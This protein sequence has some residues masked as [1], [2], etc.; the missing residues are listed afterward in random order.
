M[1]K[2][3]LCCD[4]DN[5]LLYS[6]KHKQKNDI[7]VEWLHGKEQGFMTLKAYQ[8]FQMLCQRISIVPVT[9]RS[10]EQYKR[11]RLPKE[12]SIEYAVTT[13]GA[14]LLHNGEMD[15]EWYTKS[16]EQVVPYQTELKR[17]QNILIEQ[18]KYLRCRIID[19]M[20]L[21]AYGKEGIDINECVREYTEKTPLTVMA[22]GRKIYFLPPSINKGETMIR[23]KQRLK[24]EFVAAAGDSK[25]DL[26]MLKE[27]DLAIVPN[28]YLGKFLPKS[29]TVVCDPDKNFSEFLLEIMM[30][31]LS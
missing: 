1:K 23:L 2:I 21:F 14:I 8:L 12:D 28:Q 29:N 10:L 16:F 6:Y 13:N 15:R 19:D 26:P 27:S 31:R 20:Y 17:L 24:P 30:K 3:L 5:T 9:T 25:I 4:L 11:I 7:C 18:D 22:S